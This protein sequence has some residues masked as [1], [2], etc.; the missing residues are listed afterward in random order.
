MSIPR[1]DSYFLPIVTR[2]GRQHSG[3]FAPSRPQLHNHGALGE[4]EAL[5][6][7]TR[8]L[9]ARLP[10]DEKKDT[11]LGVVGAHGQ[12]FTTK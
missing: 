8:N 11:Q 9:E 12:N 4:A 3:A 7:P 1:D 5:F 2:Q 10:N 6:N